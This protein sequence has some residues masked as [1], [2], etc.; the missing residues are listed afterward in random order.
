[1]LFQMEADYIYIK[2]PV[3]PWM[4][5]LKSSRSVIQE[6][7]QVPDEELML[8]ADTVMTVTK[9]KLIIDMKKFSSFKVVTK[10]MAKVFF[11]FINKIWPKRDVQK[12]PTS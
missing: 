10:V 12:V 1:M 9:N 8:A 2:G 7:G 4:S 6:L 5:L 3:M 11:S